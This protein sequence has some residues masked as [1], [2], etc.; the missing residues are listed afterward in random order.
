MNRGFQTFVKHKEE[1]KR[2]HFTEVK[3]NAF[4]G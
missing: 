3:E 2:K 1:E 4:S